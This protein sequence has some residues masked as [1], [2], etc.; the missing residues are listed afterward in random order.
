[1]TYKVVFSIGAEKKLVA[2]KRSNPQMWRKLQKILEELMDHPRSGTG[3]PEP[4]KGGGSVTYS[5]RLSSKDRI[6]YDIYD[7]TIVVLVVAI[8]GHYSDK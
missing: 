8:G 1:M 4:L 6:V 5:R 7:E 3:H 2:I